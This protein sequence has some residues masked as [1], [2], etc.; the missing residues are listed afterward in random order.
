MVV[1]QVFV[2]DDADSRVTSMYLAVT[3]TAATSTAGGEFTFCQLVLDQPELEIAGLIV[4]GDGNISISTGGRG[5]IVEH[6]A[7]LVPKL[8]AET[9]IKLVSGNPV[10]V[11]LHTAEYL[12]SRVWILQ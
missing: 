6:V 5:M 9:C 11:R 10:Q 2:R 8:K 12:G 3:T 7:W 1:T 4:V